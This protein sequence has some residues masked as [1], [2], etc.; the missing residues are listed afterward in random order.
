MK[1]KNEG[2]GEKLNCLS[3]VK[4][5]STV[6]FRE[7]ERERGSRHDAKYRP[8]VSEGRRERLMPAHSGRLPDHSLSEENGL[9]INVKL[10]TN[11]PLRSL[12]IRTG[13]RV[14]VHLLPKVVT[15]SGVCGRGAAGHST[16]RPASVLPPTVTREPQNKRATNAR[17]NSSR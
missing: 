15:S 10:V 12:L 5:Y 7:E 4:Y 2:H 8:E 11:V 13:P 1:R 14:A 17:E 16:P 6:C 9:V 3:C